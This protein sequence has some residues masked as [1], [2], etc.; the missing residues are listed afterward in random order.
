MMSSA[1]TFSQTP[2]FGLKRVCTLFHLAIALRQVLPERTGPQ[3][4]QNPVY[5]QSVVRAPA[6][7]ITN[8]P[9]QQRLNP[10]PLSLRQLIALRPINPLRISK[11]GTD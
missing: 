9:W 8:L 6:A 4:P 1:N 2:A 11:P 7:G 3:D 10:L 5:E